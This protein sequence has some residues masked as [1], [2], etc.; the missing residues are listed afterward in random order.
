M[1]EL[2]TKEQWLEYAKP[3]IQF[4]VVTL[5]IRNTQCDNVLDIGDIFQY[6]KYEKEYYYFDAISS[7][8]WARYGSTELVE[9]EP[10]TFLIP[11]E[12]SNTNKSAFNKSICD[13]CGGTGF[14]MG[15]S[16]IEHCSLGC[17]QTMSKAEFIDLKR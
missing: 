6:K 14:W 4:E 11:I 2:F 10:W 9:G 16:S 7:P 8:K 17:P 15:F 13:E 1:K 5:T 3:G 12:N